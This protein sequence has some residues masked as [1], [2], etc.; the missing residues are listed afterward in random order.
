MSQEYNENTKMWIKTKMLERCCLHGSHDWV[1]NKTSSQIRSKQHS[2][3]F[4]PKHDSHFAINGSANRIDKQVKLQKSPTA[5]DPSTIK[6]SSNSLC[7]RLYNSNDE[8]GS[9]FLNRP[10]RTI[11]ENGEVDPSYVLESEERLENGVFQLESVF[12]EML[13]NFDGKSRNPEKFEKRDDRFSVH[14][15]LRDQHSYKIVSNK[16]QHHYININSLSLSQGF[17]LCFEDGQSH[18]E[19]TKDSSTILLHKEYTKY[20][21]GSLQNVKILFF[22]ET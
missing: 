10:S 9:R 17:Q 6:T 19:W 7:I 14:Y 5:L 2:N 12:V 15:N 8:L 11:I 3:I 18:P 1:N 4:L 13:C 22:D 20:L 21:C 16:D